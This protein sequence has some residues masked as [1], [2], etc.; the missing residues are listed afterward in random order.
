M[1]TISNSPRNKYIGTL[2]DT[3]SK[4]KSVANTYEILPEIP[5]IGGTGLGDMFLG[6]TPEL[7]D[8]VSYQGLEAL[9]K[10]GN[11]AT[12]G[13]GTFRPDPRTV[14]AAMLGTDVYGAGKL[15]KY[16]GKSALNK[17][18][19]P[20]DYSAS[21]REFL[22]RTGA[23]GGA[24]VLAGTGLS[25]LRKL[26]KGAADNVATTAAK[27][28]KYNTLDEYITHLK[29]EAAKSGDRFEDLADKKANDYAN[30]KMT[31]KSWE[32]QPMTAQQA[33]WQA[34]RKKVMG[35]F[36]PQAK[37]E[38]KAAYTKASEENRNRNVEWWGPQFSWYHFID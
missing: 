2:A 24:A 26:G 30:L 36:S 12:G 27:K 11:L 5:L 6:K 38:M 35:E 31:A 19:L 17:A 4:G 10:G 29:T 16:L 3:L 20:N 28:Y 13:I 25:G 8:D 15:A 7:M 9:Y 18:L 37:Q 1:N 14:D 34:K 32:G 23:L 21:R 22:K 33:E